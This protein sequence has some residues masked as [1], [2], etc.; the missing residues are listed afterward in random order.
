MEKQIQEALNAA[1]VA[2]NVAH[3]LHAD[4]ETIT[5]LHKDINNLID[6]KCVAAYANKVSPS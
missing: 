5:L 4:I 1:K 6:A 2:L 3:T